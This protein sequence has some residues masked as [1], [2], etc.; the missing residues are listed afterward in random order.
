MENNTNENPKSVTTYD[1]GNLIHWE[2]IQR[3]IKKKDVAK[4]LGINHI[5]LSYYFGRTTL[6][7]DVVWKIS[8]FIQ[9]NFFGFLAEKVGVP[10]QTPTEKTL[11]KEVEELQQQL[12]YLKRENELLKELIK[13]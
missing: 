10:Y 1:V 3:K 12:H 2:I 8:K 9:F 11:Q 6:Q 13:K 4:H 5:N 7:T